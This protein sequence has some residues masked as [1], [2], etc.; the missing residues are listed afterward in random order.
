MW[1]KLSRDVGVNVVANLV[2]AAVLAFVAFIFAILLG[3]APRKDAFVLTLLSDTDSLSVL[4]VRHCRWYSAPSV[5][6]LFDISR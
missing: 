3:L 1:T 5:K 6:V 4:C 2:A